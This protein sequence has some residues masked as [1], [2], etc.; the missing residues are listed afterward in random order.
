MH[1]VIIV[2]Y[3]RISHDLDIAAEAVFALNAAALKNG[4]HR[5]EYFENPCTQRHKYS[6]IQNI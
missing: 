1:A 6:V 5:G 3:V 2:E 4:F